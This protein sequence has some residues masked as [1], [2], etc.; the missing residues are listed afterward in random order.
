L[1]ELVGLALRAVTTCPMELNLR[2]ASVLRRQQLEK[3][4]PFLAAAAACV[5]LLLLGWGI[6]FVRAAQVTRGSI[7]Q[8]QPKIGTMR[9]A[10]RKF[11]PLRRQTAALDKMATPLIAAVNE[12]GYW[13]ELLED[14]NTR[15]P[16]ADIWVTE[17]IPLSGGRPVGV[18]EKRLSES[19]SNPV[20]TATAATS[21]SKAPRST[22]TVDAVLVRGLYMFNPKQEQLVV[23]YFR[24][25]IGS[26]LFA[27][28]A[29]DQSRVI[30]STIPNNT[31]W[32][33]PYELHLDL[34]KPLTLLP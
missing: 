21:T 27:V 24:N 1:G 22:G 16:A 13:V 34:R 4:R 18:D 23:D 8:L 5:I 10:E 19:G 20:I 30:K 3:R 32:A 28:N 25:L 11:E 15:L 31:E 9:A 33:F 6:F 14:L 26:P 12:R 17:L 7:E 29:S 2:P